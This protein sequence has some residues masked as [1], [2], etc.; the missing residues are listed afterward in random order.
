MAWNGMNELTLSRHPDRYEL[1]HP[2]TRRKAHSP[3]SNAG[4]SIRP[5]WDLPLRTTPPCN[6][7]GRLRGKRKRT[8]RW[9][10]M[11]ARSPRTFP[12]RP[13]SL[14]SRNPRWP[15]SLGGYAESQLNEWHA[16]ATRRWSSRGRSMERSCFF[17]GPAPCAP[18]DVG[19]VDVWL[20]L[21]FGW[22]NWSRVFFMRLM[23]CFFFTFCVTEQPSCYLLFF[24]SVSYNCI[25]LSLDFWLIFCTNKQ[26]IE[27]YDLVGMRFSI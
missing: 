6:L 19:A 27:P 25:M 2:R 17:P 24:V 12:P 5:S 1:L 7:D 26:A 15:V 23:D 13:D 11:H 8:K 16:K 14:A 9:I 18:S 20:Y 21:A 10:W 3:I 22:L 4:D